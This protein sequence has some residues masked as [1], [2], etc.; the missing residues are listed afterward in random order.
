MTAPLTPADCDLREFPFMPLDVVRLR[1]S[2]LSAE[3]TGDEF[4]CAVLLWCASWHQVPAASLPDNDK[5]LSQLAGFGRVVKE[6]Q[7]VR[8]GSLR[9]WIKCSDGR[10]YHPVVAEK[11]NEALA[12]KQERAWNN[13]CGR[14]KKLNQR[15]DLTGDQ[16]IPYPTIE[17]FLSP[18]YVPPKAPDKTGMSPGTKQEC[19]QGHGGNVPEMT[20]GKSGRQGD[21]QG[22]GEDS[23]KPSTSLHSVDGGAEKNQVSPAAQPKPAKAKN[24]AQGSRLPADWRLPKEWGDWALQER[25][26]LSADDVRREA[27]R[28]KDHWLAQ[29]GAKGRK[30]DWLATWRNWIRND[31]VKPK[32]GAKPAAD[33]KPPPWY[34]QISVPVIEA[35]AKE[36]GL[37]S[38]PGESF[39]AFKDRV[40]KAHKVTPEMI[41]AAQAE[42][43]PQ[44]SALD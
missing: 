44:R 28:F 37:V 20:L 30:A 21:G 14:I 38:H 43:Y 42:H 27:D 40:V 25:P 32:G 11:A 4:R 18:S 13:E 34:L 10:L 35:K 22:Q 8:E 5:I 24:S 2:D 7:K 29:A 36:I 23:S 16:A 41:R 19:P 17:A 3:S 31:L 12:R 33:K 26:E 1:D 39:V 15:H 6:W 9:G